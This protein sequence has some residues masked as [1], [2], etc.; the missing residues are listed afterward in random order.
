MTVLDL[1]GTWTRP[2]ERKLFDAAGHHTPDLDGLALLG[3]DVS[4]G[5]VG[6]LEF[7]APSALV[8]A[9]D[10]EV[11]IDDGDDDMVVSGFDSPVNDQNVPIKDASLHHG[12]PTGAQEVGRLWMGDEHLGEVNALGTQVFGR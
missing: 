8:Q 6:G 11:T 3:Y 12:V 5:G 2:S 4:K 7:G 10:S 9:L 1:L